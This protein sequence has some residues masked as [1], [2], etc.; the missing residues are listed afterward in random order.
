MTLTEPT[1]LDECYHF[2]HYV[3]LDPTIDTLNEEKEIV[4]NLILFL[5]SDEAKAMTKI[6]T[7]KVMAAIMLHQKRIKNIQEIE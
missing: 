5:N 7:D 4:K 6:H 1:I 2:K 3:I